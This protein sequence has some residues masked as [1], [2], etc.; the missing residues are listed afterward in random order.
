MLPL[1]RLDRAAYIEYVV[2]GGTLC[3]WALAACGSN[4][5]VSSSDA[6]SSG[7]QQTN[8]RVDASGATSDAAP[9]DATIDS[10]TAFDAPPPSYVDASSSD[11]SSWTFE[12]HACQYAN[13]F[14]Q[15]PPP[16]AGP[17]VA[18]CAGADAFG[19]TDIKVTGA[20]GG[21]VTAGTTATITL[22]STYGGSAD[23]A[24]PSGHCVPY[25]C[26]AISADDPGVTF[27]GGSTTLYCLAPGYT[28]T[29]DATFPTNITPGTQVRFAVWA[30][31]GNTN[32]QTV[33][34]SAGSF[35]YTP[36]VQ[37]D[38]TLD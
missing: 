3:L 5:L 37:W 12:L 33:D 22:L 30:V 16:P 21:P 35:C 14:T 8:Q 7:D 15:L 28:Y 9:A 19:F 27:S 20:D 13:G 38:V 24:F 25:P 32:V 34:G 1:A 17:A 31:S 29:I 10:A 18:P 23:A 26:L 36:P 11:S 6:G 2:R 4:G